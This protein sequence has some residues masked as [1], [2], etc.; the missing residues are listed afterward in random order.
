MALFR[1]YLLSAFLCPALLVQGQQATAFQLAYDLENPVQTI[2]LPDILEEVSGLALDPTGQYLLANQDEDGLIFYIDRQSG[3]LIREIEFWDEGD[4]EGIEQVGEEVFVVKSTGTIYQIQHPGTEIQEVIKHNGFLNKDNDVEGLGYNPATNQLLIACK[5]QPGE[6]M[7]TDEVKAIYAF[8]LE[9]GIFLPLP[10]L[11][12]R[13]TAID[14]YL[15]QCEPGPDH[16]SI[17]SFFAVEKEE[18]DL[19]PSSIAVHPITG[20]YYLTSSRGKLLVV[21]QPDGTILHI[22]KLNRDL[23][24]QP[25]GLCFDAA[26]NMFISNEEKKD[27]PPL[28]YYFPYQSDL[29]S[30]R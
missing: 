18:F 29:T 1:F 4:Y 23:H 21:L 26:G 5:A 10:L 27:N 13:R 25:E 9:Q 3:T 28:I 14:E 8:D 7:S 12:I 16:V 2:E 11:L 17:C 19:S 20:H 24:C 6:S 15:S 22:E 30:D